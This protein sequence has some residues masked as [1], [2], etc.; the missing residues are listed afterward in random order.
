[1]KDTDLALTML[2]QVDRE[3][4]VALLCG[5]DNLP[6]NLAEITGRHT[7]SVQQRISELEEEGLVA[8]KGGGV[9]RLS[10][11]GVTTARAIYR[12]SDL[13]LDLTGY[14]DLSQDLG[15]SRD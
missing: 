14:F 8:N 3:I 4:L 6:S 12:E 13:D 7:Q 10:F 5:G 11:A 1:M 9:Y 2:S 15:E